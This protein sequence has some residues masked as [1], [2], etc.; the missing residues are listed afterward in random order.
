LCTKILKSYDDGIK[1]IVNQKKLAYKK[2]L[3][4]KIIDDQTEYKL[5]RSITEGEIKDIANPGKNL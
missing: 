2:C 1:L 3:Q 5:I 4:T